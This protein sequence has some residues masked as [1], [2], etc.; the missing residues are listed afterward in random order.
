MWSLRWSAGAQVP[1]YCSLANPEAQ[2]DDLKHRLHCPQG[3][4]GPG[5]WVL[6]PG[7][8]Q[9]LQEHTWCPWTGL[10]S[11]CCPQARSCQGQAEP[12]APLPLLFEGAVAAQGQAGGT[13]RCCCPAL[14]LCSGSFP[15]RDAKAGV[16]HLH[17][18]PGHGQAPHPS[19]ALCPLTGFHGTINPQ[20]QC[21]VPPSTEI[22]AD[23]SR[24]LCSQG[25]N[26]LPA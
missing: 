7:I 12:T 11:P 22:A 5:T 8:P 15:A 18:L 2:T 24:E 10:H 9:H 3:P 23:F 6:S 16:I 13:V 21:S 14:C 19:H 4:H 17:P 26:L 1:A 20:A 25:W